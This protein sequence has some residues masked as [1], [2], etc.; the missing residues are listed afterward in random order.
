L[1]GYPR[2]YKRWRFFRAEEPDELW[3]VDFKGPY[4][5]QGKRYWFLVVID[6]F[7]GFMVAAR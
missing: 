1:N 3:Q 7:S 6:D 5:V 4:R 2:S